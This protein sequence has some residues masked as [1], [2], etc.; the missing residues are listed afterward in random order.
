MS[1]DHKFVL[2]V[3]TLTRTAGQSGGASYVT[4]AILGVSRAARASRRVLV[5]C[6]SG[7]A[8]L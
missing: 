3:C 2:H 1:K 4:L 7:G 6:T 5:I 8:A